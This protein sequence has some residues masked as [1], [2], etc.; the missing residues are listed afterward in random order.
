MITRSPSHQYTFEGVTYPGV[1]SILKI[2]DK[3]D[4][5]MSWAA[6]M[7]AEAAIEALPSLPSLLASVGP[8]GVTKALTARSAWKR[9]DR[10]PSAPR[11]TTWRTSWRGV[12]SCPRC[13]TPSRAASS[14]TRNGGLRRAGSCERLRR[15]W[16]TPVPATAGHSTFSR[17]TG[18]ERPSWRT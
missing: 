1:T 15:S 11:Y 16:S 10:R 8:V 3:S 6:R 9:D 14:S 13:Q 5:L 18:T 7:T 4:A 12:S 17:T 2:I